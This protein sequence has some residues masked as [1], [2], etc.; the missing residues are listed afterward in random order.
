MELERLWYPPKPC[1]V[2][3]NAV[4]GGEPWSLGVGVIHPGP[5]SLDHGGK[6]SNPS[7]CGSLAHYFKEGA[8][9]LFLV[10]A[11]SKV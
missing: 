4:R 8:E 5:G 1:E 2:T 9:L 11:L 10:L 3:S 7:L 6:E